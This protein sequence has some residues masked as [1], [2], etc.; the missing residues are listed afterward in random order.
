[1]HFRLNVTDS[2]TDPISYFSKKHHSH[3]LHQNSKHNESKHG[4]LFKLQFSQD[5]EEENNSNAE[6]AIGRA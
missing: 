6:R 5:K 2:I 3:I 4:G 1:M